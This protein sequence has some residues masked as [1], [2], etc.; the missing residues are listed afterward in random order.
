MNNARA[1]TLGIA[2]GAG[3]MF[4]FDPRGGARRRAVV[5]QKSARTAHE[6]EDA[7]GIGARDLSQRTHGLAASLYGKRRPAH[8]DGEVLVA[9]VRSKLGRVCSHPRA[10][11]VVS[12]G[13]GV[14]ELKG[15]ILHS[16]V[17]RVR[18]T[19]AHVRGVQDVIDD[20]EIHETADIAGLQGKS[21]L[22]RS[23]ATPISTPAMRLIVGGT[24][25]LLALVSLLRGHPFGLL[26]GGGLAVAVARSI[27]HR[28]PR[29]LPRK[30]GAVKGLREAYPEGS[31]WS[32]TPT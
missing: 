21:H 29:Q 8:A 19:V 23:A 24:A 9:R 20:L 17:D 1:L 6:V 22:R 13:D 32:P 16:D 11:E 5:R 3:L 25:A 14:I 27:T 30:V 18:S 26:A 4:L 7:V 12:K 28:G 15:P 10:V 31:E 2:L